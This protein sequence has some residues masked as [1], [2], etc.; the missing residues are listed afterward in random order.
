MADGMGETTRVRAFYG[1]DGL[2]TEI[3]T[4]WRRT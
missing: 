4:P 3:T 1:A 2:S